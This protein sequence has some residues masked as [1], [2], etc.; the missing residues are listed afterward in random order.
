MYSV[1]EEEGEKSN[2]KVKRKGRKKSVCE[3]IRSQLETRDS[4]QGILRA[5]ILLFWNSGRAEC[6]TT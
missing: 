6:P 1:L 5:K 4:S 3:G 2:W